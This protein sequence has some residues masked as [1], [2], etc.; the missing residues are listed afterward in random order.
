MRS[1]LW[2]ELN[3]L[4]NLPKPWEAKAYGTFT[5]DRHT[6][7]VTLICKPIGL[8][9]FGNTTR[10]HAVEVSLP[11]ILFGHNGRLIKNAKEFENAFACLE[12]VLN[13]LLTPLPPNTRL[14]PDGEKRTPDC[15]Y[16]RVDLPWQFPA[17][18]RVRMAL[19]N[20]RHEKI[21]SYPS[22]F[23]GGQTIHL[24]GAFLEIC[25]YDKIR[26]MKLIKEYSHEI[27][28]VEFRAKNKALSEIYLFNDGTGYTHINLT[29]CQ[30]T[31]RR[32]AAETHA[33]VPP[34]GGNGIHQFIA[35]VDTKHPTLDI[36]NWYIVSRGLARES[37]RK[38]RNRVEQS[39]RPVQRGLSFSELF[40]KGGWPAPVEVELPD[41]EKEHTEWLAQYVR[42]TVLRKR[43]ITP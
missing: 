15:H 4:S 11:R 6:Q 21:H 30:E 40:P 3:V 33:E 41:R 31:M 14:I 42:Q 39:R 17:E 43:N 29:W 10:F 35:D 38:F 27:D 5:G 34:V 9:I 25:A 7:E 32:I 12:F 13:S 28:R 8:R 2:P 23:K 16:T 20:A 26:E 1:Q 36:L 37:A 18:V 24:K 22:S 19:E